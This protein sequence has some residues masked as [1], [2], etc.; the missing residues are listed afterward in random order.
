[1]TT[2]QNQ[3]LTTAPLQP[4]SPPAASVGSPQTQTAPLGVQQTA[5]ALPTLKVSKPVKIPTGVSSNA[6]QHVL[7][8]RDNSG[9][10]SG[11]KIDELNLASSGLIHELASPENKDGFLISV[12]EFSSGS[13]REMFAQSAI[14]ATMPLAQ[15]EGGTNFD[16]ALLETISTIEELKAQPNPDGWRYLRPQVLFLSDGQ[17]SVSDK[18]IADIQEFADVTAIAY[19]SDANTDTLSR[20]ASDGQIHIIGTNGGEL[21]KFLAEV[22]RTLSQSLADVR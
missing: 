21:R 16:S 7:L 1:M 10:M 12:I 14:T 2:L 3:P 11:N 9:S 22:G 17:S 8:V 13:C 5:T 19:G 15:A 6:K 18:N 4:I 20:I